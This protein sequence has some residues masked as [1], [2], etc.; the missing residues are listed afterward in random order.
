M[1]YFTYGFKNANWPFYY[2]W[3]ISHLKELQLKKTNSFKYKIISSPISFSDNSHFINKPNT[4]T[5]SLF[6]VQPLAKEYLIDYSLDHHDYYFN[7]NNL[8][9]FYK[10]LISFIGVNVLS[11]KRLNR[12]SD[13]YINY[14]NHKKIKFY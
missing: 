14:I 2:L 11:K 1:P 4:K 3:S 6:N 10:I 12:V 13:D 9:S 5:I 7:E 8:I